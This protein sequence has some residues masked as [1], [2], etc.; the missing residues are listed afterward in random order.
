MPT[1]T[2][3]TRSHWAIEDVHP[4]IFAVDALSSHVRS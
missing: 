1:P 3:I 4:P 2:T